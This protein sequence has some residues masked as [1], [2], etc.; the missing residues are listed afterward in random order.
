[1]IECANKIKLN[2]DVYS[3]MK[4]DKTVKRTEWTQDRQT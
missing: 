4:A 2:G 1:M 3:P